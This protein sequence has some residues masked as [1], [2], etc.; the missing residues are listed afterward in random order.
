[1]TQIYQNS[2]PNSLTEQSSDTET[3]LHINANFLIKR[4]N[5]LI[6]HIGN[7]SGEKTAEAHAREISSL[8]KSLKELYA[9]HVA[10]KAAEPQDRQK[11]TPEE[12]A[13]LAEE[14]AALIYNNSKFK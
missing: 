11:Y 1:M 3:V 5:A 4:I 10:V 12:D 8:A 6:T 2:E 13:A 14:L 7:M 9:Y